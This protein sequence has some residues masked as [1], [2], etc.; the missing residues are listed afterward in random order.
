MATASSDLPPD[1]EYVFRV[2]GGGDRGRRGR[3]HRADY[4]SDRRLEISRVEGARWRWE[5][6]GYER[7][8]GCGDHTGDG[9]CVEG[10]RAAGNQLCSRG[11]VVPPEDDIRAVRGRLSAGDGGSVG[12]QEGIVGRDVGVGGGRDRGSVM[13]SGQTRSEGGAMRCGITVGSVGRRKPIG[14]RGHARSEGG[15]VRCGVTVGSVGRRQ[16]IGGRGHARSEGGAVRCGITVGGVERRKPI[17]GRGP[18]GSE[19]GAVR[20]GGPRRPPGR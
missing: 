19:G 3:E 11:P 6:V 15:A 12:Y 13:G 17:G 1:L 9:S 2:R 14:G 20:G 4:A 5:I 10:R 18:A 16:P 7:C 8:T